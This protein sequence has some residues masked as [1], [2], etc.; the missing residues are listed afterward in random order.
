MAL[1][2]WNAD[3]SVG[4]GEIDEQHKKL[5]GLINSLNDAM[6]SGK[7]KDI[8]KGILDGMV[9]YTSMHFKTEEKY[10]DEFQYGETFHHKTEH[11]NFVKKRWNS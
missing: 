10:M 1:I 3:L 11:K 9:N 7:G 4:V 8:L 6:A 2:E 5:I